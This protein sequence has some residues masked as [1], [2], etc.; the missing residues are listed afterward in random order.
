MASHMHVIFLFLFL[1]F[2]IK[3]KSKY[4]GRWGDPQFR[5]GLGSLG[6]DLWWLTRARD[7][8]RWPDRTW[9]V[10]QTYSGGGCRLLVAMKRAGVE[11]EFGF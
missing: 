9:E 1:F 2:L 8:R 5:E 4:L 3:L 7:G 11:G 6:S 10:L